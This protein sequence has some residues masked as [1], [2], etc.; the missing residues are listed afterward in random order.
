MIELVREA[1]SHIRCYVAVTPVYYDADGSDEAHRIAAS[2]L[3]MGCDEVSVAK[4]KGNQPCRI[5][6]RGGPSFKKKRVVK[7]ER[8]GGD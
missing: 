2:L 6:G 5:R 1:D 8:A 4:V 7:K 3:A